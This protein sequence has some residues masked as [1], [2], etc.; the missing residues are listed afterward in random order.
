MILFLLEVHH[1]L[2]LTFVFLTSYF[3]PRFLMSKS[4]VP[5]IIYYHRIFYIHSLTLIS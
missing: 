3:A 5:A 4:I 1:G 2:F